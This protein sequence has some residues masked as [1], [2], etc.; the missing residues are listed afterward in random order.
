MTRTD[1][2]IAEIVATT[3]PP[4][5]THPTHLTMT[6]CGPYNRGLPVSLDLSLR[7][8]HIDSSCRPLFPLPEPSHA[9][10]VSVMKQEKYATVCFLRDS[11]WPWTRSQ[12]KGT[13]VGVG[14][15]MLLHVRRR[16]AVQK[17]SCS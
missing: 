6:F 17:W 9:A 12:K 16:P 10:H 2:W 3:Q 15:L 13:S 7:E 8:S 4:Q 5:A 11:S 1:L 14:T